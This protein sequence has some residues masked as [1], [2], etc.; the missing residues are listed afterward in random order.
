[1]TIND[2]ELLK[3]LSKSPLMTTYTWYRY[4]TFIPD[5]YCADCKY[6]PSCIL[7]KLNKLNSVICLLDYTE[8]AKD[9]LTHDIT[10]KT[11]SVIFIHDINPLTRSYNINDIT[12]EQAQEII[13]RN[14]VLFH[15][16]QQKVQENELIDQINEL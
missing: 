6:Y 11:A 5:A 15:Q 10:L 14:I 2:L 13:D 8:T 16:I 1:M 9:Y 7:E 12:I 3:N 4:D